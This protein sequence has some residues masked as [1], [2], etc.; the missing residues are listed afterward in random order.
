MKYTL[1]LFINITLIGLYSCREKIDYGTSLAI[2]NQLNDSIYIT[3]YPKEVPYS[4]MSNYKMKEW[5]SKI[6]YG[7]LGQ[8]ES[9]TDILKAVFDSIEI[10]YKDKMIVFSLNPVIGYNANLY[11]ENDLWESTVIEYNTPDNF[12]RNAHE[13]IVYT[14]ILTE[15]LLQND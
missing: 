2:E 11:N 1:I 12:N 3:V 14:F 8:N 9:P 10:S 4:N 13:D 15:D 6:I 5:E 7:E